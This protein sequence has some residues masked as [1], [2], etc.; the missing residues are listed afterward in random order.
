MKWKNEICYWA[1]KLDG[2][3]IWYKYNT[4][5]KW[6]TTES[7]SWFPSTIYVADDKYAKFKKAWYDRAEV[8]Y[9]QQDGSWID[10]NPYEDGYVWDNSLMETYELR[11][12]PKEWHENI[13]EG[14]IWCWVWDEGENPK[15][16]IASINYYDS[17]DNCRLPFVNDRTCDSWRCAEPVEEWPQL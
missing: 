7:P 9:K 1:G 14:G 3:K 10:K 15:M 12:K 2:T 17:T 8:Q 13:T 4:D 6:Y 5:S 11:I 16:S